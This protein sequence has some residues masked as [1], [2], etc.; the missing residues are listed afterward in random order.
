MER[1]REGLFDPLAVRL[2][3]AREGRLRK[4]AEK[5]FV[6]VGSGKPAGFCVVGA[7]GQGKS[8]SLHYLHGLALEAGFASSMINLDFREIPFH[9][10]RAVYRELL[11]RVQF[12]DSEIPLPE[13]WR[14][15]VGTQPIG[16]EDPVEGLLRLIP[17]GMPHCFR[18]VLTAMAMK[19]V[20]LSGKE[21]RLKRH[22][23]FRPREF[24][25]LLA[26]ALEGEA[27]P[28]G[29]LRSVLKYRQV[30][31]HGDG[32]L[33]CRGSEP[34]PEMIHALSCLFRK[35]G[36]RGWALLFDEGESIA[37]GNVFSRGK[38]YRLMHRLL[39]PG[40]PEDSFLFP[41]FAFTD[42]FFARMR[43][44]DYDRASIR[45]GREI[46]IFDRNYAEEWQDLNIHRLDDLSRRE[47][48]EISRR[49]VRLHAEAYKWNPPEAHVMPEMTKRLDAMQG[50]ET[51]LKLKA[52]VDCLDRVQQALL[53]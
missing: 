53:P 26:R 28:L 41:V 5:A 47:W 49:L 37:Q 50:G 24:P 48:L 38:A 4:E 18:A 10:F 12:P 30:A 1:L 19:D 33:R 31:F 29:E 11:R 14:K 15:W 13:R 44:E 46:R 9:D 16:R 39:S 8:H 35:M 42:D 25:A 36:Y 23:A 52:M 32:P 6:A 27:V 34:Y 3:T 43:S 17:A 20:P 45:R 40:E 7:Y 2:L 22:A 51:R 21:R